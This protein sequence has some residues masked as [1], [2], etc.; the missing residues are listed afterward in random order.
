MQLQDEAFCFVKNFC[1]YSFPPPLQETTPPRT[2]VCLR[3]GTQRPWQTPGWI[4]GSCS[5]SSWDSRLTPARPCAVSQPTAAQPDVLLEDNEVQ[6]KGFILSC[7]HTLISAL[8]SEEFE[9]HGFDAGDVLTGLISAVQCK[10]FCCC[11]TPAAP[12]WFVGSHS[13]LNRRSKIFLMSSCPNRYRSAEGSSPDSAAWRRVAAV[14][15][16]RCGLEN[17]AGHRDYF[18]FFTVSRWN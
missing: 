7:C 5:S 13:A 12:G 15:Y 10:S 18:C 1:G 3:A 2:G 16:P 8:K 17:S 9:T 14:F 11:V 4:S 6:C